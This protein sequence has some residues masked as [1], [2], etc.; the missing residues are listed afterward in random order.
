LG[1]RRFERMLANE[2]VLAFLAGAAPSAAGAIIGAAVPLTSA[3][4]ESWQYPILAGGALALLVL[5]RGVVGTLLLAG[6]T[7]AAA[8]LL[9]A[10]LP[11]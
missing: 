4:G 3:L 2:R 10:P 6:C 8:V 7:G 9:G 5:R 11:H 1:A